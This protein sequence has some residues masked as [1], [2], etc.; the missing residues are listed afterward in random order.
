LGKSRPAVANA[1]RLLTL[2]EKIQELLSENK[3]LQA[4]PELLAVFLMKKSDEIAD[5]ISKKRACRS[6]KRRT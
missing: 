3:L 4:M 5:K 6:G 1:L 2:S